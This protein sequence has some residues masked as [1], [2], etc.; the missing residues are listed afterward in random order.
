MTRTV[1]ARNFHTRVVSREHAGVGKVLYRR[2]LP[3][4]FSSRV[5]PPEFD[6]NRTRLP[7]ADR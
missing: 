1:R 6:P 2:N 4:Q 5:N 7:I 3:F